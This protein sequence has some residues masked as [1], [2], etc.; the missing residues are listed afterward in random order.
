MGEFYGL[1]ELSDGMTS[2]ISVNVKGRECSLSQ[3]NISQNRQTKSKTFSLV[4]SLT[5]FQQTTI[6]TLP[7][8]VPSCM[9]MFS[10]RPNMLAS[11]K[12]EKGE[13][14]SM[15]SLLGKIQSDW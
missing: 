11:W 9:Y 5:I 15:A 13:Y 8:H 1:L 7:P 3:Y 4:H 14:F 2:S 12:S 10:R 6:P